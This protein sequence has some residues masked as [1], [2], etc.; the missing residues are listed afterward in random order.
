MSQAKLTLRPPPNIDFVQ[1]YPGI[2]PGAPDRPQAAV[3]GA[4]EVRVGP[5]GI[6][7][8]WVRIELRKVET[9]PGGGV[10]NTFFDFVGQS[11][12]NLWQSGEEYSLLTTQ[13]F[14]FYI[15]IP[16][17]IPPSIAL[18]K[19]AGV[20]Y[21]LIATVCVKGK[22]GFLRRDKPQVLV[23]S[24][25]IVIDKHELHSTWPVYAQP[26]TRHLS[27]DGVTLIVERSH[28]CY[29]PGDRISVMATV[30]SDSLHTVILRG[31][32]FSLKETTVF[33]A[34]P[35]TIGKKAAPQVKIGNVGEQKVPVNATIYGGT[36]H[37]AELTV[38]IPSHHTSTTLNAARHID[39]T[40]PAPAPTTITDSSSEPATEPSRPTGNYNTAP[41]ANGLSSNKHADEFGYNR[42][43][44]ISVDQSTGRPQVQ[45]IGVSQT[46]SN[47]RPNTAENNNSGSAAVPRPRSSGGR[48][49]VNSVRPLTVANYA[50]D[51][52]EEVQA[53]IAAA[54]AASAAN[55]THSRQPSATARAAVSGA[56]PRAPGW[57]PAEEEKKLLYERAKAQVE[58]VQGSGSGS[59]SPPIIHSPTPIRDVGP[60]F[61]SNGSFSGRPSG[62]SAW[63]TAEEE[64]AKLFDAA[65]AKAA[66]AQGFDGINGN[67]SAA[68]SGSNNPQ[69]AVSPGAA[70]YSQ[71]MSAVIRNTSVG[72]TAA[73]SSPAPSKSRFPTAE[74]EKA[75]L[76]LFNEAKN[77]VEKSQG[78]AAFGSTSEQAPAAAPMSSPISY[79]ALYPSR[80]S[81]STNRLVSP[82]PPG[83]G[84]TP[85]AF[86]QTSSPPPQPSNLSEKEKFRRAFEARDAAAMAAQTAASPPISAVGNVP[87]YFDSVSPPSGAPPSFNDSSVLSEKEI[88]RRHH[89]EQ[90]AAAMAAAG[91]PQPP[92]PRSMPGR[93]LPAPRSIP[94]PPGN[95]SAGSSRLMNA[96]EE[97]ARL[98][99]KYE[100]EEQGMT[101]PPSA[102]LPG[103]TN[104]YT[105]GH[106]NGMNG[107][108][109]VNGGYVGR[110]PSLTAAAMN[111]SSIPP[112]PPLAPKPPKEY[113]QETQAED[114]NIAAQ[115]EAIDKEEGL[116]SQ[117]SDPALELRP[118]TP[119][120]AE[121]NANRT[122]K[123]PPPPLPP[124]VG[125]DDT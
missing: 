31:F 107:A 102:S 32:E 41:A 29:G 75:A 122:S 4:I 125:L 19:G 82:A 16:E 37:K 39:I 6:K 7:A 11:P 115:I 96:A 8:K 58:L 73:A 48:Q 68:G 27:M 14:S 117:S 113:I 81:N 59:Q 67:G 44:G 112:P 72:S 104:G 62:S 89:A 50:D 52:P 15:R 23:A 94:V 91:P 2:P 98:R 78:A 99:A 55:R 45:T 34:G 85:P 5:Q 57:L 51:M 114:E 118:F 92:P 60:I 79:D 124:K 66:R 63:P 120:V 84:E 110:Q 33:R 111:Y 65:R 106:T 35:N 90:D 100:A 108:N 20:K 69:S 24:S 46:S 61:S 76:R 54:K 86:N 40:N 18:E 95:S 42:A 13:D 116:S 109:G 36:Q 25:P 64:K 9:L 10:T 87:G 26:E 22:K 56:T 101:P 28:T 43:R 83:A 103:Y 38:T 93:G 49:A 47:G 119:F 53:Q 74:E 3:K 80:N 17:S 1:G 21:E 71:A 77:A 121:F 70:L 30:K 105:N 123:A 88:L 97:K 12:I